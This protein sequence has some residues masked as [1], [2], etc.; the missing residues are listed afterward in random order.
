MVKW[1]IEIKILVVDRICKAKLEAFQRKL[2]EL[3]FFD[4]AYGFGN[5]LT[6]TYNSL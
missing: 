4:E 6:E 5:I 1:K 2:T 3:V